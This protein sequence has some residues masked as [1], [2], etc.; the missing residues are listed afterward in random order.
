MEGME[1]ILER[2][3]DLLQSGEVALVS[4]ADRENGYRLAR[5]AESALRSAAMAAY[6]G[7]MIGED[8]ADARE[9]QHAKEAR[10]FL[11]LGDQP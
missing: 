2:L 6:N 1:E 9:A 11:H 7:D 8:R 3:R 10:R 5:A 4:R